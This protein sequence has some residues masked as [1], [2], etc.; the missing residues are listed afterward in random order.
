MQR[1][2]WLSPPLRMLR[3]VT[4]DCAPPPQAD[5]PIA[6]AK[7]SWEESES[8]EGEDEDAGPAKR[9]RTHD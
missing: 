8:D 4:R 1:A 7:R 5:E 2:R 6:G 9:P 3:S